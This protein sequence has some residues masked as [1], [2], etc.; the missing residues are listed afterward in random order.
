LGA[1]NIY[2]IPTQNDGTEGT[3]NHH[4]AGGACGADYP[5]LGA[6]ANGI[7]IS[8]NEIAVFQPEFHGSQIY[9]ISKKA[10]AGGQPTVNVIVFDTTEASLLFEDSPGGTVWPATSPG[11]IYASES[12]GTEYFL[13]SLA[14]F[15]DTGSDSR[16]RIWALSNT[17]SL[18]TGSPAL[19]LTHGVIDVEP[20][21][22]P[23]TSQQK[24]GDVPLAECLN[25]DKL[26]TPFGKGCWRYSLVTKRDPVTEV[27]SQ[28]VA[29][30]TV[31]FMQ[32]VMLANG[33]LWGSLGTALQLDSGTQ[34]GI[35]YFVIQPQLSG[36]TIS[37]KVVLQG[38]L[39]VENNNLTYPAIGVTTSGRGIIAFTVIGPDYYP[40]AGY[41]SLNALVGAGDVHIV[42]EGLGPDDNFSAY[43]LSGITNYARWGD[44][45]AAAVDKDNIWIAS[46][47]IGQTCNYAD[48]IASISLTS[49][50]GATRTRFLNW[51]TRLSK[52]T[53]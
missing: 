10:L 26:E 4:C 21:S 15:S 8:S 16:L 13:S 23:P 41:A 14:A 11:G 7:Y 20:Y 9:A 18:N 40:S 22:I 49:G 30:N 43:T 48:Y 35:A 46:E 33:K 31:S 3:P 1:W 25:D 42:A 32:Q 50:C 19:V 17:Q 24:V 38:Y 2:R 36:G 45:G 6:D 39:G 34:T 52:L 12:G 37:G 5:H 53:P 51:Y 28:F 27:E 29:S 44:Y 47:Y